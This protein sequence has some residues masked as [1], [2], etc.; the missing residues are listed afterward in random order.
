MAGICVNCITKEAQ[1]RLYGYIISEISYKTTKV[2]FNY[3]SE[4]RLDVKD[5]GTSHALND[6]SIYDNLSNSLIKKTIFSTSYFQSNDNTL[7]INGIPSIIDDYLQKR[8][9]LDEI[10]EISNL[11]KVTPAYKFSYNKHNKSLKLPHRLSNA[12]DHWGYY[13]GA[14]QN[15]CLIGQYTW[16]NSSG[17]YE[18]NLADRFV[19][20]NYNK[21]F[22]L[23]EIIHTTKGT[24]KYF[25]DND[26]DF[27]PG[28]RIKEIQSFSG[29]TADVQSKLYEYSNVSI[30]GGIPVYRQQYDITEMHPG[31]I[32]NS[33]SV[34][35]G[36]TYC[37][38]NYVEPYLAFQN[39]INFSGDFFGSNAYYGL[40]RESIPNNGYTESYFSTEES[41]DIMLDASV[42]PL[43]INKPGLLSGKLIRETT[44]NEEGKLIKESNFIY[45][46]YYR[47]IVKEEDCAK[48]INS[49]CFEN[50]RFFPLYTGFAFLVKKEEI[51][52]S[53]FNENK[54]ITEYSYDG[55]PDV[56][57]NGEWAMKMNLLMPAPLHHFISGT[58]TSLSDKS[59]LIVQS[60]Y[61]IDYSSDINGWAT[62]N[63][64]DAASLAIKHMISN[65]I[66]NK[67]IEQINIIKRENSEYVISSNLFTY[68]F[69]STAAFSGINIKSVF[70][71]KLQN[72]IS[73]NVGFSSKII[74]EGNNYK[75]NFNENY[76]PNIIFDA[77]D[78]NNNLLQYHE[79]YK[80]NTALLRGYKKSLITVS[81]VNAAFDEVYY[82]G[83]E[84]NLNVNVLTDKNSSYNG[85]RYMKANSLFIGWI[86]PNAKTYII[87]YWY[88]VGLVWKYE[89]QIYDGPLTLSKGTGYDDICI[90]PSDA[91]IMIYN[92]KPLIGLESLTD[93][94]GNV[95]HF[96]YDDFNRLESIKDQNKD[97][98]GAYIYHYNT[99]TTNFLNS[100][101]SITFKKEGCPNQA[102]GSSIIYTIPEGKYSSPF[103]QKEADGMA[104]EDLK[105]NGQAYANIHGECLGGTQPYF[106]VDMIRKFKAEC[107][108]G[109]AGD[110]I[111]YIVDAGD[112]SS[113]ISLSDANNK[114]LNKL[115]Y[116]GQLEANLTCRDMGQVEWDSSVS[117]NNA[118][119]VSIKF[120]NL[121]GTTLL[122]QL[123]APE[124]YNMYDIHHVNTGNYKII[125]EVH[126]DYYED[127][128]QTGYK[129]LKMTSSSVPIQQ[130]CLK[131]PQEGKNSIYIFNSVSIGLMG[132]VRFV[133]MG[134]NCN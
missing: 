59:E 44:H 57:K 38:E 49:T 31:T 3:K 68:D 80:P 48:F 5:G 60:K 119:I 108:P 102:V 76:K 8:L 124:L 33:G 117:D 71:L 88:L 25:Y 1:T 54:I 131:H 84:E 92:Y 14:S 56:F 112:F 6:I 86:K 69:F 87:T 95:K 46:K 34:A 15:L 72:P 41:D 61:P 52:F 7:T 74:K 99:I 109:Q 101:T 78:S 125:V 23:D 47:L 113:M 35:V 121:S 127:I 17:V 75:F 126:G 91:K 120:Y 134:V 13:N 103:S 53:G 100:A 128:E 32:V 10:L 42:Y 63:N 28:L 77:Y 133:I 24:T 96:E 93:S 37:D 12:Q 29:E 58:R 83:F 110:E 97:I 4:R 85:L 90:Y 104:Q 116:Q 50:V 30:A 82:D 65:W 20:S 45:R 67:P 21:A 98:I 26:T 36:S 55:I 107:G 114:A 11:G 81:A 105:K 2:K 111:E 16:L 66:I 70:E 19:H 39:P 9:R 122:Y 64:W 22:I 130:I 132:S 79:M 115:I 118:R 94:R 62:T 73:Y 18:C 40:V 123:T 106:N 43:I 129:S 89:E 27:L 51:S